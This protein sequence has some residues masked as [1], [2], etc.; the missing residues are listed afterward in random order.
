[1]CTTV[2]VSTCGTMP[3]CA[4]IS[5]VMFANLYSILLGAFVQNKA[6]VTL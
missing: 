3:V 2:R 4:G 1:M 6:G 5:S